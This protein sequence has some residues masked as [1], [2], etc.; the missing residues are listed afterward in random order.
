MA[1]K[2]LIVDDNHNLLN[3]LQSCLET[4]GY[5]VVTASDGQAAL[6]LLYSERPDLLILDIIMPK[7]D[8]WQVCQRVREMS[9]MPI[10]MLTAQAEKKDVV[11]GFE[12]G[13][14]D[15]LTKPFHLEELL[16]RVRA[17]LRRTRARAPARENRIY[18]DDCLSIDLDAR[19]VSV[20]GEPVKLTPTEYRLLALLV[21]NKGQTL[22]FRHILENVWGADLN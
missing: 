8:G 22:E 13:V 16:A 2:I 20:N 10:I 1:D 7:M 14:D 12:L 11:Q 21:E 5:Q 18:R 15:Y 9:D 3:S 6:R 19:R 4:E 17:V